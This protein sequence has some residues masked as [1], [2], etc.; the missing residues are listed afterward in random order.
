[1]AR[2]I[3]K[4]PVSNT[5]SGNQNI[6]AANWYNN[7]IDVIKIGKDGSVI[8]YWCM[9]GGQQ[10][11]SNVF[12]QP[13]TAATQAGITA[14]SR[15]PGVNWDCWWIGLDGSVQ[16]MAWTAATGIKLFQLAPAGS[17]STTGGIKSLS[18]AATHM[19]VWWIAPD[20]AI[21]GRYY[22]SQWNPD[23]LLVTYA[24]AG[25]A[26]KDGTITGYVLDN[27]KTMEL[28]YTGPSGQI[29]GVY[30][31]ESENI[32]HPTEYVP[33]AKANIAPNGCV[34]SC[35]T[36]RGDRHI[37]WIDKSGNIK[38]L[39]FDVQKGWMPL[40]DQPIAIG[41]DPNGCI[42]AISTNPTNSEIWFTANDGTMKGGSS[43]NKYQTYTLPN[44]ANRGNTIVGTARAKD[45]LEVYWLDKDDVIQ[46]ANYY[47]IGGD[48]QRQ[49]L[50]NFKPKVVK[51]PV[52][53]STFIRSIAFSTNGNQGTGDVRFNK[54]TPNNPRYAVQKSGTNIQANGDRI[55]TTEQVSI[56]NGTSEFA[57][58]SP[59]ATIMPG[60]VF[61][62]NSIIDGSF[63]ELS[64]QRASLDLQVGVLAG[65]AGQSRQRIDGNV[66]AALVYDKAKEVVRS[67][68]SVTL[69]F[70]EN[71]QIEEIDNFEQLEIK[72]GAS[73]SGFGQN[74]K[75][76]FNYLNESQRNRFGGYYVSK[77]FDLFI[78]APNGGYTDILAPNA[79]FPANA[80]VV[81]S[82]S[83]GK[84]ITVTIETDLS[85]EDINVILNYDGNIMGKVTADFDLRKK[86]LVQNTTIKA[87]TYG[88]SA[89]IT[90]ILG[91]GKGVEGIQR[92]KD[93][94]KG[95][96]KRWDV[97]NNAVQPI[98]YKL[99]FLDDG[100][101]A[102][103]NSV[104]EYPRKTC[105]QT[106]SS[107]NIKF[108]G[109]VLTSQT[110]NHEGGGVNLFGSLSIGGNGIDKV[111]ISVTDFTTFPFGSKMID[112]D[113]IIWAISEQ[114][115]Y[116]FGLL[117]NRKS[118]PQG[119]IYNWA[120]DGGA[121]ANCSNANNATQ[122]FNIKT[123][124]AESPN[125]IRYRVFGR[126]RRQ[127]GMFGWDY[128][129][130]DVNFSLSDVLDSQKHGNRMV[131]FGLN[132]HNEVIAHPVFEVT[133]NG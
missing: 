94:L 108:L 106:I 16:S 38:K 99:N 91:D 64:L 60:M 53:V 127:M 12:A 2:T 17:A 103:I 18:R 31:F 11:G 96:G 101:V 86:S 128:Q 24:P 57:L 19:E 13:N 132:V 25:S 129:N 133:L 44:S 125:S 102:S 77:V 104:L 58:F 97:Q 90:S 115:P 59:I 5:L 14:V 112:V 100:A 89:S 41:A 126:L 36:S 113:P 105:V 3:A 9:G 63:K 122:I 10:W 48:W 33:A 26:S 30:W 81:S 74:V 80:C 27:G 8:Q 131:L 40:A 47:T 37:F 83:F 107:F 124:I 65:G 84:V 75:A 111:K 42:T 43:W 119:N 114:G 7:V 130:Y 28:L 4:L 45:C 92:L 21:K 117:E 1:M 34:S 76:N 73:Y 39:W 51:P 20:G 118:V 29:N 67:I 49:A 116:A 70:N 54:G 95:E 52:E 88:T 50:A 98:A 72:A 87:F 15:I 68:G 66:N 120:V 78:S 109:F 123:N 110:G 35:V 82:V 55:C 79:N 32:W 23:N 121:A 62:I 61:D 69:P 85:K 71:L 6:I 22:Y 46:T 56:K 93:Y